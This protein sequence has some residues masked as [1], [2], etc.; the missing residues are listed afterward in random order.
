ME[1]DSLFLTNNILVSDQ[2]LKVVYMDITFFSDLI[3]SQSL[4]IEIN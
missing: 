3:C 1:Y 4:K 2:K